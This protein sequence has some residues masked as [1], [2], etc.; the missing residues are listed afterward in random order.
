VPRL[1]ISPDAIVRLQRGAFVAHNGRARHPP[2]EL[3]DGGALAALRLF[4][5]P[6]DPAVLR[7]RLAP[8]GQ[9]GFDR[10]VATLRQAGVL[11]DADAPGTAGMDDCQ[12]A[13]QQLGLLARCLADLAADCA[14]LSP[15]SMSQ[16]AA[17]DGLSVPQRLEAVVRAIGELRAAVARAVDAAA[18]EQLRE[19]GKQGRLQDARLH[20]GAGGHRLPG[21]INIDAHPA[22]LALNVGR[23]LPFA[24]ATARL[25]FASH[26]FEHL[27]YPATALGFLAECLR[28][29][30]PG[31]RIRLIVPDIELYIRAYAG[32]DQAFFDARR[33]I[34]Q[35]L[36]AG[37]TLLEEFL[38]YAGAGPDPAAFLDSHK[39]AY[40]YATL[41]RM[42][43]RAG[44]VEIERSAYM[45]SAH[46]ELRV[47]ESSSV[48]GAS[49]A[50]Q[51][52]SL[53]VEAM[54][55]VAPASR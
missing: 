17:R 12:A 8:D 1:V 19:M 15:Q 54:R 40:D 6:S 44:F 9:A 51:H 30:Q 23:R 27:Y 16:L 55:P 38:T 21:W 32:N 14:A 28:V 22:E 31:G 49:V 7:A 25:I 52:Y 33:G 41:H 3:T 35:D 13:Q 47:D 26:V 45:A 50:G 42:L 2:V 11:I 36:P 18:V 39:Y 43:V 24:D 46:A 4:A 5:A 48:A 20:I 37:R 53:F 10:F 34:W 29:L